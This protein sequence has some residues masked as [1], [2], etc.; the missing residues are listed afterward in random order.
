MELHWDIVLLCAAA[1]ALR[2]V[3]GYWTSDANDTLSWKKIAR[4]IGAAAINAVFFSF[5][6]TLPAL[7]LAVGIF[8][9]TIGLDDV[10]SRIPKMNAAIKAKQLSNERQGRFPL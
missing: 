8:F 5:S 4:T 9:G 1:A 10:M 2:V 6:S 7:E 3:V